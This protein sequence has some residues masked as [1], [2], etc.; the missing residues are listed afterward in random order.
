MLRRLTKA[1]FSS[2][3]AKR[4]S[5]SYISAR[6]PSI[7]DPDKFIDQT[8]R[9]ELEEKLKGYDKGQIPVVVIIE[10]MQLQENDNTKEVLK[11][12]AIVK[13]FLVESFRKEE[14]KDVVA[15]FIALEDKWINFISGASASSEF[16]Y[17]ALKYFKENSIEGLKNNDYDKVVKDIVETI[18]ESKEKFNLF[19]NLDSS[20]FA[21]SFSSFNKQYSSWRTFR[22]S[23]GIFLLSIV[24]FSYFS[25][26]FRTLMVE[27]Q[28]YLTRLKKLSTSRPVEQLMEENCN[29]CFERLQSEPQ[30]ITESMR[31]IDKSDPETALVL[32]CNHIYH[33]KC[34][35]RYFGGFPLCAYCGRNYKIVDYPS[36]FNAY[37]DITNLRLVMKNRNNLPQNFF[38]G[39]KVDTG[40]VF[41][42]IESVQYFNP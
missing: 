23:I 39:P 3:T 32:K 12:E 20:S 27:T 40:V 37:L 36:L 9:E 19:S 33:R 18:L 2:W 10:K 15:F 4:L 11:R 34:L 35:K 21:S 17:S 24:M 1:K 41:D 30:A 8:L 5:E 14:V 16:D 26:G 7:F 42:P 22:I 13:D 31:I 6:K 38:V 28:E 29:F 25:T